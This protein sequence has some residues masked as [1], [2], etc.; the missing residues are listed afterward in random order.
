MAGEQTN[1]SDMRVV[2]AAFRAAIPT[3]SVLVAAA[4]PGDVARAAVVANFSDNVLDFLEVH[5]EE[6]ELIWPRLLARSPRNAE[7]VRTIAEQH[8]AVV[9]LIVEA[10]GSWPTGRTPAPPQ[11]GVRRPPPSPSWTPPWFPT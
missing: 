5:H 10:A 1:T 3:A 11:P 6:D 4:E 9:D 2:H 7:E 8:G